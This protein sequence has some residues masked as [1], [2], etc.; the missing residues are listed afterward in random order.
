MTS[1]ALTLLNDLL[2]K[3]HEKNK[4]MTE[5]EFFEFFCSQ[6]ILRDH[7]LGIPDLDSGLIGSDK[8]S[9]SD[10]GVDSMYVLIND[11]VINESTPGRIKAR[12]KSIKKTVRL[13]IV[14]I[15]ASRH[16]GF[17][18]DRITRLKDTCENIFSLDKKVKH[19]DERYKTPLL[20]AVIAFRAAHDAL[21]LGDRTIH[22]SFFYATKGDK[23]ILDSTIEKKAQKLAQDIQTLLPTINQSAFEFVGARELLELATKAPQLKFPLKCTESFPSAKKGR[24]ALVKLG[25]YYRLIKSEDTGQMRSYLFDTNVRDH[26]GD[27]AV[28]EAIQ[29]TLEHPGKEEFWWLNNGIT[30][31][32]NK[33][34]GTNRL[35]ELTE[36]QIV[37]GL[38]TSQEIFDYF[39][40]SDKKPGL[41]KRE[42]L[43]RIIESAKPEIQDNIIR[44]T[45]SQTAIPAASLYAT[46]TVH[47]DIERHFPSEQLYYDRRKNSWRRRNVPIANVIGIADLAQAVAAIVLQEPDHARAR[48]ARYFSKKD[49]HERVFSP[50]YALPLYVACTVMKKRAWIALRALETETEHRNNLLYYL[51]MAAACVKAG[52]AKPHHSDI[53]KF[54][55]NDFADGNIFKEAYQLIRPLYTACG[56]DDKAA[57]GKDFINQLVQALREKYAQADAGT[58]AQ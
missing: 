39:S 33:I 9:G 50:Q 5:S 25:E 45:N 44:C 10:G 30:I 34:D 41:D 54:K 31:I 49:E 20:K 52:K 53:A 29:D 1:N 24:V 26:Q 23:S 8:S 27:V 7:Q 42:I 40:A 58:G 38:Q 46:S 14:I 28:N 3:A 47:R 4:E 56:Q 6:N 18:L 15:Q 36:P 16:A 57:K 35:L 32:A 48:P 21:V 37:N 12:I 22:L 11:H 17:T 43:V 2:Q 55:E 19:F 51:L 13:D